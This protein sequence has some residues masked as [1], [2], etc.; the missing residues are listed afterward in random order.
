MK[1]CSLLRAALILAAF[2]LVLGCQKETVDPGA[3][4]QPG[5]V[6]E[7]ASAKVQPETRGYRDSF[8]VDLIF[9]P[10]I[11]GGWT[12]AD[13]DAP[14]WYHGGGSGHATHMGNATITFNTHTLRVAGTVTIFHAPVGMFHAAQVKPFN[15]GV[16][17]QVSAVTYDDKGNSIWFRIAE[18]GLP[19]WH[20]VK[21]T[22]VAAEGK[23]LIVGGSGKFKGA[24]GETTFHAEFD[25]A[26][27][28]TKKLI[29]TTASM[30]QKGWIRY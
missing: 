30:W 8:D 25:Q 21:T 17:D 5:S 11:A 23:M 3:S 4:Q 16:T 26:S 28:D 18:G 14:A 19:T 9:V 27:L 1:A 20:I 22:L 29:F 12:M 24:T 13:F 15:V 10:D 2:S 7:K 6:A